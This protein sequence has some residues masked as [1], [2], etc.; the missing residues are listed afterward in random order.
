[1]RETWRWYGED[2]PVTLESIREAGAVG[3]VTALYH[4]DPDI[5][6][7]VAEVNQVT[8]RIADAG[9]SWDVV[10]SIP[11]P[12]S[13]KL[14]NDNR[15][16]G[17]DTFVA[18]LTAVAGAGVG[19]VCYNFMPTFDW[20]RTQANWVTSTGL[21]TRF[22]YIDFAIYDLLILE[23]PGAERDYSADIRKLA[24]EKFTYSLP[25]ELAEIEKVIVAGL[26]KKPGIN[27]SQ[28]ILRQIAQFDGLGHA[29]ISENLDAFIRAV[30]PVAEELG[31]NLGIHPDD[32]PFPVFGLPRVVSNGEDLERILAAS[33]SPN[34]GLTFCT[35]SLGASAE[36]DVCDLFRRFGDRVNFLHL[37]NVTIDGYRS[38]FED[39]HLR[40]QTD[41]VSLIK[42]ILREEHRRSSEEGADAT[43]PMRPD[44][45][46]LNARDTEMGSPH[47]Y[48]YIGRLKGLAELR[49][50]ATALSEHIQ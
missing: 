8:A 49:G 48:S 45:G 4:V 31:V 10:E 13:V 22:D 3:I 6:W 18:S 15:Q 44:H 23:R 21:A 43:I 28:N 30:A 16:Q 35:G 29:E 40:G 26:P 32:P 11:I 25:A 41:M 33:D 20:T 2:D 38:F 37:R 27:A 47:G 1:M 14:G 12:N 50:V 19:T 46:H 17:I 5:S 39:D 9:L 7:D 42:L 24:K 34:H 36:N